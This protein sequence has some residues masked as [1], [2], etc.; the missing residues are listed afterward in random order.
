MIEYFWLVY[1][2]TKQFEDHPDFSE[3]EMGI[4]HYLLILYKLKDYFKKGVRHQTEIKIIINCSSKYF[5]KIDVMTYLCVIL[6]HLGKVATLPS[7]PVIA[8]QLV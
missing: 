6:Q 8:F 5:I 3:I 2:C 7:L 1:W 4:L